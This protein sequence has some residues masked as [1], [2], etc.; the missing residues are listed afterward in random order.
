ME[1]IPT[2][3]R[4]SCPRSSANRLRGVSLCLRY[5]TS[6]PCRRGRWVKLMIDTSLVSLP[7]QI[8]S[9]YFSLMKP[10]AL[11]LLRGLNLYVF[12]N[13]VNYSPNTDHGTA[14]LRFRDPGWRLEVSHRELSVWNRCRL[15]G[16]RR[17]RALAHSKRVIAGRPVP[18]SPPPNL[19][20]CRPPSGRYLSFDISIRVSSPSGI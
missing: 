6:N 5:G 18:T 13:R 16:N 3:E 9:V 1:Q 4:R 8:R 20:R 7:K 2:S 14:P 15:G 17:R 11:I 10:L 12:L 19:A